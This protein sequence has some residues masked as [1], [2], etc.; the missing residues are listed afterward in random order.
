MG[1]LSPEDVIQPQQQAQEEYDEPV[2]PM[3]QMVQ[4]NISSDFL[5]FRIDNSEIL[6]E[7]E[8]QLK[9]EVYKDGLWKPK[10]KRDIT[11]EGVAE[12]INIIYAFGLN[13]SN[14]LG[15]IS[16]EEIYERCNV[17]WKELAKYIFLHG[18]RVG[19]N[20]KHRGLLIR[21]VVFMVHSALSRSEAG[22]EASQLSRQTQHVE[23]FLHQDNKKQG[24]MEKLNPF[25]RR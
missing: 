24:M 19:I 4:G 1:I 13:K 23:H 21:K 22:K 25:A 9:G 6:E 20:R 11:D 17:I 8:H 15:N 12:I 18:Y 2:L 7:I 3:P 16:H 10:F 5:K 14:L